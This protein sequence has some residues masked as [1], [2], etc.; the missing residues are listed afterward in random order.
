[1][2]EVQTKTPITTRKDKNPL[3]FVGL[4]ENSLL[5]KSLTIPVTAPIDF[6]TCCPT[7]DHHISTSMGVWE[8]NLG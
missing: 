4:A 6:K 3:V 5:S 2:R 8:D 7:V 1:M